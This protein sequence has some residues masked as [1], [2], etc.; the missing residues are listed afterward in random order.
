MSQAQLVLISFLGLFAVHFVLE[1]ALSV[2]NMRH[3]HANPQV[4][5]PLKDVIP[6]EAYER[7]IEYA[8]VRTRFGH[9]RAAATAA[10][11]LIYLFSGF[12]PW[13]SS[14]AERL[15]GGDLTQGVFVF[16]VFEFLLICVTL[17]FDIY[18]TFWIE[19]RFGFNQT[20]VKTFCLDF[21][22]QMLLAVILFVPLLY[23]LLA[24]VSRSGPLWWLWAALFLAAF[25]FVMMIVAPRFIAPLFNKFTPLGQ[26]EL[27]DRVEALARQCGFAMHGVFVMDG[28]KRSAHSN[29]YFTGIGA[30]RRIVLYDTLIQQMSVPEVGAVLAHEIGHFKR[31]HIVKAL[32]LGLFLLFAGAYT[33]S[34]LIKWPPFFQAFG[35]DGGLANGRQAAIS[36]VLLSLVGGS[37]LFWLGPLFHKLSR[38]HEYEAD[39]YAAQQTDAH[40]MESA[41]LKLSEKNLSTMTPHP[42][43]SAYH[44]SHPTLL[45]RINALRSCAGATL[46]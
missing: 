35:V 17:V 2:I 4:P 21:L 8:A 20:D 13:L 32:L 28:S 40:H 6:I 41:L 9:V 29:A 23:A 22:K 24:F 42:L 27:R 43:Y 5:S 19:A 25:Q 46:K 16:A 1:R 14:A 39:A 18:S 33:L 10:I 34:L 30:S 26:G 15:P 44:Y 12:L 11:T 38:K 7:S 3:I 37:F 31:K 36:L 45:E